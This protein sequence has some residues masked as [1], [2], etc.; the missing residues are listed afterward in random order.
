LVGNAW[1]LGPHSLTAFTDRL[2]GSASFPAHSL[3][4]KLTHLDGPDGYIVGGLGAEWF[5]VSVE[6]PDAGSAQITWEFQPDPPLANLAVTTPD[7]PR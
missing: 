4:W 6:E 2:S 5:F 1:A 3:S 7:P